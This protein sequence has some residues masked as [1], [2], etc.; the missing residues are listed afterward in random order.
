MAT[1]SASR[2]NSA[3]SNP[4]TPR[5][6]LSGSLVPRM[7]SVNEEDRIVNIGLDMSIQETEIIVSEEEDQTK[8]IDDETS[9]VIDEADSTNEDRDS[10][11]LK[12]AE[13][14]K[15]GSSNVVKARACSERSDSGISDC[16]SHLTT[17]SCTSTPLLGKKFCIDEEGEV[18]KVTR[19]VTLEDQ[20]TREKEYKFKN[21]QLYGVA[22]N[23][24]ESNVSH[25]KPPIVSSL[26]LCSKFE[27]FNSSQPV[28]CEF[29]FYF[30]V[31]LFSS[32]LYFCS[33][34]CYIIFVYL[35]AF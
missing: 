15:M 35:D 14:L 17:S 25:E 10:F 34:F 20:S 11:G 33:L 28:K 8:T 29:D 18:Y 12:T 19:P 3:N 24:R 21:G 5:P 31:S 27:S 9:E 13:D 22:L 26:K 16:S 6:S 23:G 1:L 2:R 32:T 4:N 30:F 7:S